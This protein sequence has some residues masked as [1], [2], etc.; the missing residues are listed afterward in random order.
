VTYVTERAVFRG[1]PDGLELTEVAP[2]IDVDRDVLAHMGFRPR[3]ADDLSEMDARLFRP[4]PM[5]LVSD[6]ANRPS[7]A[8]S[9]RVRTAWEGVHG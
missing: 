5:G 1:G 6:I 2:G 7:R 8:P 9:A 4:E 3:I